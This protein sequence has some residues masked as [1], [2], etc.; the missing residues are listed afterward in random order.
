M[1][2]ESHLRASIRRLQLSRIGGGFKRAGLGSRFGPERE[3]TP[4]AL[5]PINLLP[6]L[7]TRPRM[8]HVLEIV[9]LLC[10]QRPYGLSNRIANGSS[11]GS[12]VDMHS[13]LK[14][15]IIVEVI[16]LAIAFAFSVFYFT[17]GLYRSS[18]ILDV[19]L[20][21][22]WVLVAG[23]LLVVFK[24]R[25]TVREE[26][27]RR[28]YLSQ[29]WLYNH[30]IGYAPISGIMPDFDAYEFVT[31]AA[32]ALARMS[33]G[34]EVASAP[35]D[36]QPEF[37]ISTREFKFHLVEDEESPSEDSVVID[38]WTGTLSKIELDA[39]GEHIYTEIGSYSDAKE[40]SRIIEGNKVIDVIEHHAEE[41]ENEVSLESLLS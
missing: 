36:F 9:S 25:S 4:G 8:Y 2:W 32:E 37:L 18:H 39:N 12:V 19:L 41:S 10:N 16:V 7:K 38:K 15:A 5:Q 1:L 40:L 13:Q 22:L 20:L 11:F 30:E 24:Q 6:G 27:V 23:V 34:F 17:M 35:D 26:I 33:Y 29:D 3:R 28:F 21:V 31:F 14:A